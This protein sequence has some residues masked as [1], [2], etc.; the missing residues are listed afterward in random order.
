VIA[1]EV[2]VVFV[3]PAQPRGAPWVDQVDH[4]NRDILGQRAGNESLQP[5]DLAIR[6]VIALDPVS[7][8]ECHQTTFG[9]RIT[10]HSDVGAQGFAEGPQRGWAY[11]VSV[12][13]AVWAAVRKLFALIT[14]TGLGNS[15]CMSASC[16]FC[17][18][19]A[20]L[21]AKAIAHSTF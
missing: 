19:G 9:L 8:A 13:P 20:S 18:V 11:E 10:E 12:A 3:D 5:V 16:W 17:I 1:V 21:L 6:T 7:A 14:V 4:H 15:L 2:D